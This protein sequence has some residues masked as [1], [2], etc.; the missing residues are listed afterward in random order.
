MFFM[1]IIKYIEYYKVI[2]KCT[3]YVYR[4]KVKYKMIWS[5]KHYFGW[6]DGWIGCTKGISFT[7]K[8]KTS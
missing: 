8:G 3:Y 2:F 1:L 4:V 6:M 7:F 5:K